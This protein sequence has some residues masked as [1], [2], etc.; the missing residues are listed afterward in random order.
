MALEVACP[1]VHLLVAVRRQAGLPTE[2]MFRGLHFRIE[3]LAD[4]FARIDWEDFTI[5]LDRA[6]EELGGEATFEALMAETTRFLIP[7]RLCQDIF[8]D[9]Q[10]FY[11]WL[12]SVSARR[13]HTNLQTSA[14]ADEGGRIL[15]EHHIP[16]PY[17]PSR[18]LA[19]AS[20]GTF[21]GAVRFLGLPDAQVECTFDERSGFYRVTPPDL[22]DRVLPLPENPCVIE[23]FRPEELERMRTFLRQGIGLLGASSLRELFARLEEGLRAYAGCPAGNLWLR[24]DGG[25]KPAHAWGEPDACTCTRMLTLG[26]RVLGRLDFAGPRVSDPLEREA[27]EELLAWASVALD[28]WEEGRAAMSTGD[29]LARL[30]LTA[31]ERQIL[32]LLV[33]GHSDKQIAQALGTSPKTVSHQVGG[34][35]RKSGAGNRTALARLCLAGRATPVSVH[36]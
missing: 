34:L 4:P 32:A 27:L 19:I 20:A 9:L 5:L 30:K 16:L 35:L 26:A 6:L 25:M 18:A 11:V 28:P 23:L 7:A 2:G 33:Q 17:R 1:L 14:R 12:G 8:P 29:P 22:R 31:R 3:D 36:V 24:G 21:R 15:M 10:T 13:L